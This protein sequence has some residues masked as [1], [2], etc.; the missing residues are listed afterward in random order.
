[1]DNLSLFTSLLKMLAAL[2]IVLG[3]LVGSL[4]LFRKLLRGSPLSAGAQEVIRVVS[5]RH[6]GPK[7]MIVLVD[8]LGQVLIVGVGQ[9]QM[10]L[11][12]TVSDAGALEKLRGARPPGSVPETLL[13]RLGRMRDAGGDGKGR[14]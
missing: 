7:N 12:G 14:G 2:A 9:A 1:M 4:F 3:V 6:L 11:L 5:T 13:A 10:S 8:V